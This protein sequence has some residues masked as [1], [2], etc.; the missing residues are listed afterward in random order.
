MSR[1]NHHGRRGLPAHRDATRRRAVG[2]EYWGREAPIDSDG[3]TIRRT[4][5]RRL[6]KDKN[7]QEGQQ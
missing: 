1:T 3:R 6:N 7:N 5:R 2:Y 4:R